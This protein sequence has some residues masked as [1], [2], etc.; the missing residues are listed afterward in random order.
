M[1][2]L[3]VRRGYTMERLQAVSG[4]R[5]Q[6]IADLEAQA[7][8]PQGATVAVLAEALGV[9]VTGLYATEDEMCSACRA[10]VFGRE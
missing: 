3:R 9:P 1:R 10:A 4:V 2:N 8:T 6:T 7:R 5:R